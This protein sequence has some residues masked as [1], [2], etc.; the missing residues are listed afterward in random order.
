MANNNLTIFQRLTHAF[1]GGNNAVSSDMIKTPST[2]GL[3]SSNRVLYTTNDKAEYERRLKTYQQQK[4]LAYQWQKVNIDNTM[5]NLASYTAVKLM[6]RD[7]DLMDGTPEIGTALDIIS[8][9]VCPLTSKGKMLNIYSNSK[10]TK[11]ILED[12]F[13]N[14]LHIDI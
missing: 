5:E 1:R 13:V 10:R 2:Q 12:L 14:R 7:V 11:S 9:E 6:Y 3:T 4:Y 8:E